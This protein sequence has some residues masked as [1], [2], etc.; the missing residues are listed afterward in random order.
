MCAELNHSRDGYAE[1]KQHGAPNVERS[2]PEFALSLVET[3]G[4][5]CPVSAFGRPALLIGGRH[6]YT[7]RNGM[8]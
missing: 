4:F 7:T 8:I 5:W 1:R 2:G 3:G 6:A